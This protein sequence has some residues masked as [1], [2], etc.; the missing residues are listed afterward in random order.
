M[1]LQTAKYFISTIWNQVL[2]LFMSFSEVV[3]QAKDNTINQV[4]QTVSRSSSLLEDN[5]SSGSQQNR[6]V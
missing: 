1:K 2:Y 5:L 3:L 6:L 4:S